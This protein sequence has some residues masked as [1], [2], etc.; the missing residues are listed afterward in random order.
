MQ[1]NRS[2]EISYRSSQYQIATYSTEKNL[3]HS[4]SFEL[5]FVADISD[6]AADLSGVTLAIITDY[7]INERPTAMTHKQEKIIKAKLVKRQMQSRVT[8]YK[9]LYNCV[10]NQMEVCIALV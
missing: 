1:S 3:Q 4:L 7:P 2:T 6:V 8:L 9:V 5:K 10:I